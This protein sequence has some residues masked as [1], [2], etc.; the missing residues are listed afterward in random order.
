VEKKNSASASAQEAHEAIRPSIVD[1]RFVHPRDTGITDKKKVAKHTRPECRIRW[2]EEIGPP[3]TSDHQTTRYTRRL[4]SDSG[5]NVSYPL[6][7]QLDLYQLIY[8]RALA[9]VMKDAKLER[10]VGP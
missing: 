2:H 9:S 3:V 4:K 6:C 10:K 7:V 5:L 1:D 8:E